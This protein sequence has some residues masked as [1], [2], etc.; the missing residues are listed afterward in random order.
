MH[1]NRSNIEGLTRRQAAAAVAATVLLPLM[2][3]GNAAA[4]GAKKAA[5]KAEKF[6]NQA[7]FAAAERC[8]KVGTVCLNHSIRL[9]RAGDKTL[10]DCIRSVRS[11]LPVAAATGRLAALN[12][13][14]LKDVAKVCADICAACEVECRK[15]EFHHKECAACAAACADMV[16]EC[17]KVIGA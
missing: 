5:P 1:T 10:A 12:S 9:T 6:P 11:M 16:T 13:A 4:Q 17:K 8:G 15:H 14:H 3:A 7:L 2:G